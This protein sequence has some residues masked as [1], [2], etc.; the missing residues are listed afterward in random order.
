[1]KSVTNGTVL[2]A[3]SRSETTRRVERDLHAMDR[4]FKKVSKSKKTAVAFLQRAGI[5]D[6][7]GKPAKRYR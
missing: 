7:T 3:A 2:T 6:S 1:M 4:T 5:L